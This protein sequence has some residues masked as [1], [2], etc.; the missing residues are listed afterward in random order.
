MLS[1][2]PTP[3]RGAVDTGEKGHYRTVAI[4]ELR[5]IGVFVTSEGT[6]KCLHCLSGESSESFDFVEVKHSQRRS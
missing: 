5:F 4:G 2:T 3:P 1:M 6:R